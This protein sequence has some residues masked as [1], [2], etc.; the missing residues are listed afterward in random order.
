MTTQPGAKRL[1]AAGGR[2]D[3]RGQVQHSTWQQRQAVGARPGAACPQSS[4]GGSCGPLSSGPSRLAHAPSPPQPCRQRAAGRRPRAGPVR[5]P[6]GRGQQRVLGQIEGQDGGRAARAHAPRTPSAP[7]VATGQGA[8]VQGGRGPGAGQAGKP[9]PPKRAARLGMMICAPLAVGAA[10]PGVG[11]GEAWWA[12][13]LQG[14]CCSWDTKWPWALMCCAAAQG[15]CSAYDSQA[16][17]SSRACPRSGCAC[18]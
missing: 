17:C 3:A 18:A 9:G 15:P 10:V 16:S 14:S 6:Q 2:V 5:R 13:G 4:R 11:S 1:W 7:A 8:E 12:G